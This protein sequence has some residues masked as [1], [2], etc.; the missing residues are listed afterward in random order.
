M[1]PIIFALILSF[2]TASFAQSVATYKP[3]PLEI[4]ADA[5][6]RHIVVPGDTLWGIAAKFLKDPFRWPE[7]WKMNAEQVKNPHRIFPGQVVIL[8][9]SGDQPQLKLGIVKLQPQ[10]RVE[11]ISKEIPAISPQVIEPFLAQPL[12][13]DAAGFDQAPRIVATQENRVHAGNGD[14]IYVSGADPKVKSWQIFRPG[15]PFVDPDSNEVLGLEAIFLGN[16]RALGG[17]A[18]D[19]TIMEIT[20]VKQEI[21]RGDRLVP[22]GRPEIASYMPHLPTQ[23]IQGRILAL[24]GG[25]GEGGRHSIVSLSRGQRDGLEMG[26][27]LAIYRAGAEVTNRFEDDK[28]QTHQ[29]PDERYGLIFIFRVFDRVSY[30]L[31]MD[32]ARPVVPGDK[33]RKP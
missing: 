25:V 5:P 16:A 29:L 33:V 32:A 9:L 15:K 7:L 2:S 26:H 10:V 31:V 3:A 1:K 6:E 30:A 27:V 4:A 28:P 20:S 8:D 17:S 18:E 13:I 14:Q 19:V 24:Y 21:G 11:Q 12:V 22:A 23:D